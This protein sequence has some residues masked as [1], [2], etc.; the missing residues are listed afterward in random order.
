ML[1]AWCLNGDIVSCYNTRKTLR[2]VCVHACHR[3]DTIEV[4]EYLSFP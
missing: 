4:T 1:A 2:C 3:H